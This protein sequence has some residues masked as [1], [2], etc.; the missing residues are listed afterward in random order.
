[1]PDPSQGEVSYDNVS[2]MIRQL[3]RVNAAN[4]NDL[5]QLAIGAVPVTGTDDAVT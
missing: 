2:K 4:C 5:D 1:M 3:M